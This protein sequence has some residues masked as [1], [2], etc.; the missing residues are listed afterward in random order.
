MTS[1]RSAKVEKPPPW[2]RVGF[3]DAMPI[4]ERDAYARDSFDRSVDYLFTE[5]LDAWCLGFPA[6]PTMRFAERRL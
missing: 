3:F 1:Y 4:E 6:G 5:E 2:A